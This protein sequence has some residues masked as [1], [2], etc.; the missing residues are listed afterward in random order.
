MSDSKSSSNSASVNDVG[1]NP[2][3]AA[4]WRAAPSVGRLV[5]RAVCSCPFAPA[6]QRPAT[7]SGHKSNHR[8]LGPA[9][10]HA[11]TSEN[12]ARAGRP[13]RSTARWLIGEASRADDEANRPS[14]CCTRGVRLTSLRLGRPENTDA[15]VGGNLL[16]SEVTCRGARSPLNRHGQRMRARV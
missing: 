11:L 2:R 1:A 6:F 7:H 9:A 15:V 4:R 13:V 16:P 10:T 8:Q 3:V 5:R 14:T 12:Y